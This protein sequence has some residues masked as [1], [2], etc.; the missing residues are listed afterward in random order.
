[1]SGTGAPEGG[2]VAEGARAPTAADREE[3]WGDAAVALPFLGVFFLSPAVVSMAAR[4]GEIAGAPL[5]LAYL[6]GVW[7]LLIVGAAIL[8]RPPGRDNGAR[9]P[10]PRRDSDLDAS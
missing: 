7:A 3:R 5:I 10:V 6:F 4:P 8:A 1:M 9:A 2:R